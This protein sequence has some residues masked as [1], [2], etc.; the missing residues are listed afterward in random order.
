MIFWR[1]ICGTFPET[2][3]TLFRCSLLPCRR[4]FLVL[5]ASGGN[6]A[7]GPCWVCLRSMYIWWTDGAG[8]N[9]RRIAVHK[10]WLNGRCRSGCQSS[11]GPQEFITF[12]QS[13]YKGG[14]F[15]VIPEV[16]FRHWRYS[17]GQSLWRK[18]KTFSYHHVQ[19]HD[20]SAGKNECSFPSLW[21]IP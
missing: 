18:E 14:Y 16:T 1:I 13:L 3:F 11:L 12:D 15:G 21:L 5:M 19:S 4:A 9:L 17:N 7:N 10:C 8:L 2:I 20:N 6:F